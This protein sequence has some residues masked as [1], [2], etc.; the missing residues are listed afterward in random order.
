MPDSW[1]VVKPGTLTDQVYEI[2]RE[3]VISRQLVPGEFIREQEVS[4]R[5]GVSRTPV[6]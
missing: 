6:S 4:E 2:L 5:L 3:K 1:P